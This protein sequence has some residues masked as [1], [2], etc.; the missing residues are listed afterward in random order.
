MSVTQV[1]LSLVADASPVVVADASPV[2]VA[3]ASSEVADASS[4]VAGASS[5]VALD[6]FCEQAEIAVTTRLNAQA[7]K[8]PRT[9]YGEHE[10][11]WHAA[12]EKALEFL[13]QHLASGGLITDDLVHRVIC[14]GSLDLYKILFPNPTQAQLYAHASMGI[15]ENTSQVLVHVF[16]VMTFVLE[17]YKDFFCRSVELG[18]LWFLSIIANHEVLSHENLVILLTEVMEMDLKNP[19]PNITKMDMKIAHIVGKGYDNVRKIFSLAGL[20]SLF[21]EHCHSTHEFVKGRADEK[22]KGKVP[23]TGPAAS[24]AATT[25]SDDATDAAASADRYGYGRTAKKNGKVSKTESS[26]ALPEPTGPT[27]T[28]ASEPAG[29]ASAEADPEP[30]A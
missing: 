10:L 8:P 24:A 18:R 9:Y 15:E 4:E 25:A 14:T 22:K 28:A 5:E 26:G 13:R 20:E 12:V 7:A 27:C 16:N 6:R 21:D 30:V 3:D 2:V 17:I 23:K 1:S 11:P 29:S 19:T